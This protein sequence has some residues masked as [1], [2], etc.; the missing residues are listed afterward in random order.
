MGGAR[1]EGKAEGKSA[2]TAPGRVLHLRPLVRRCGTGG[3]RG[4]LPSLRAIGR[5]AGCVGPLI[6]LVCIGLF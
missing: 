1:L 6:L 2:D 4:D 3:Y 5:A